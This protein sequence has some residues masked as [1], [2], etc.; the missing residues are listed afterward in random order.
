MTALLPIMAV[1]LVAF[2]IVGFALPVLP[3]HVHQGLG[4]G[5]IVVGSVT[6]SQ[7]I[8]SIVARVVGA[9]RRLS[10]GQA[11]GRRRFADGR[12]VRA[13]LHYVASLQRYA[14][15]I[16]RHSAAWAR[17]AG[18]GRELHHYGCGWLGTGSRRLPECKD[19]S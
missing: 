12:N 7:F 1:V 6:G 5:A 8:A 9:I 10:G 3:L 2:L 4:L 19:A 13:T 17:A 11:R 16:G 18:W 15:A 14:L